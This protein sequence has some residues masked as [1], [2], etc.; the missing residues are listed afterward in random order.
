[1]DFIRHACQ[2][3]RGVR[4]LKKSNNK[5]II[6][7]P[8]GFSYE[9]NEK[10][11]EQYEEFS[12][13]VKEFRITEKPEPNRACVATRWGMYDPKKEKKGIFRQNIKNL[14]EN[15]NMTERLPITLDIDFGMP[16]PKATTKKDRLL[17]LSNEY[18]HTRAPDV[19]N[20]QKF[21][22]DT[23]KQIAFRDD[24]QV[25]DM[26]IR[27]LWSDIAYTD[28]KVRYWDKGFEMKEPIPQPS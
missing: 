25:W 9:C 8:D 17:M 3:R 1:M 10:H 16:I 7:F 28:V 11:L 24:A 2:K 20:L 15:A 6:E 19:D 27:K 26:H 23:M 22:S 21:L 13:I 14:I 18:K 12:M 5:F 4:I